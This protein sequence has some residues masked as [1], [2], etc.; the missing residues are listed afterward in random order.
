MVKPATVGGGVTV[1][2]PHPGLTTGADGAVGKITTLAVLLSQ[3]LPPDVPEAI[4]PQAEVKVY[5]ALIV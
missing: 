1:N 5:L 4:E 3:L 2:N